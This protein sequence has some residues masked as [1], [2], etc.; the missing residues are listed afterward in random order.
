MGKSFT[1]TNYFVTNKMTI[2]LDVL[3]SLMKGRVRGNMNRNLIVTKY[4]SWKGHMKLQLLQ[5]IRDPHKFTNSSGECT[6]FR[7]YRGTRYSILL[8]GLPRNKRITQEDAKTSSGLTTVKTRG[9]ICIIK[10]TKLKRSR[11]LQQHTLTRTTF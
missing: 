5:K 11:R 4:K 9:S 2:Q 1:T 3:R 7:L 8:F 10:S 6:I